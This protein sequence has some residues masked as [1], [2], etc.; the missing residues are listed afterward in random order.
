MHFSFE[1]EFESKK[2]TLLGK[3]REWGLTDF[4]NY[5]NDNW[6]VGKFSKWQIFQTP[7]GFASTDNPCESFNARLKQEFTCRDQLTIPLFV[8]ILVDQIIPYYSL[9][10]REFLFYRRPDPQ[11]NRVASTLD[12]KRFVKVNDLLVNYTGT[13][14][15]IKL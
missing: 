5:F 7:P 11:C 10:H 13:I 2:K 1:S 6:L 4:V 3:W 9:N 8:Q 15:E 14:C 12:V